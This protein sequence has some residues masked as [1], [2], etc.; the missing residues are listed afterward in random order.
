MRHAKSFGIL[1]LA[2]GVGLLNG[3]ASEAQSNLLR[4]DAMLRMVGLSGKTPQGYL[5]VDLRDL[6]EDQISALKLKDAQHGAEIVGVDHDGPACKAGLLLHDIILQMN[7][8]AIEGEM[9]LRR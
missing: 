7:G 1:V 9:Q 3:A 8:Q 5:G 6:S 4:G 2:T